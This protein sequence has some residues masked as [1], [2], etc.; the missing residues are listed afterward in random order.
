MGH[1]DFG[2]HFVDALAAFR[3]AEAEVG[4]G[5][6]D[7]VGHINFVDEVEALEHEAYAA[8]AQLSAFAFAESGHFLAFE[9]VASGGGVVEE[10]EDVEEC[11][12]AAT[13]GTHDG[14]EFAGFDVEV[15]SV[16]GDSL[17]FVGAEGF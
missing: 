1:V 12:F 7:V 3:S 13:A 15:D 2:K 6:F 14:N 10:A 9:G 8:F 11:G 4:E 5:E 17:D 16:E